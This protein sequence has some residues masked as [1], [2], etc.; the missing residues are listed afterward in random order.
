[1]KEGPA[2]TEKLFQLMEECTVRQNGNRVFGG[3]GGAK[4]LQE[5]DADLF[6]VLVTA[7]LK[8]QGL[9]VEEMG[10]KASNQ[11]G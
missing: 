9:N 1:M 3:Q 10:K 2:K 5:T 6:D 7:F 11:T 4:A 8:L